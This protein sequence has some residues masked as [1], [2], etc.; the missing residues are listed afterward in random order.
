VIDPDA[1]SFAV[2]MTVIV[3]SVAVLVGVYVAAKWAI[4]VTRRRELGPGPLADSRLEQLQQSVDSI[5]IE[6]ERITEAQRFTV[7]LMTERTEDPRLPR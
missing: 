5:A 1:I 6:V 4:A 7:K 3:T 2:V